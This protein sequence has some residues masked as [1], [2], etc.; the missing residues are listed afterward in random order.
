MQNFRLLMRIA[1]LRMGKRAL[2]M[3]NAA[4]CPHMMS[5][6]MHNPALRMR[7]TAMCMHIIALRIEKALSPT[8]ASVS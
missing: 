2:R 4:W 6:C 1:T 5:M 3:H 7:N 8:A